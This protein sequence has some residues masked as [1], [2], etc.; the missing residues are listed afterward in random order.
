MNV[1]H[2]IWYKKAFSHS[3]A[4]SGKGIAWIKAG[5]EFKAL[6]DGYRLC[7]MCKQFCSQDTTAYCCLQTSTFFPAL[8]TEVFLLSFAMPALVL[9]NYCSDLIPLNWGGG[10]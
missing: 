5:H 10:R 4:I 9:F 1:G 8:G 2:C 6:Y 3:Q 7:C